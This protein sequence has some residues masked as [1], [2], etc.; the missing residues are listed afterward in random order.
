MK[1]WILYLLAG[2]ILLVC[3]RQGLAAN[4]QKRTAGCL[5]VSRLC[6]FILL[7]AKIVTFL[8]GF[9][10]LALLQTCLLIVD[11]VLIEMAFRKKRLTFG[12][13]HLNNL[14]LALSF[15]IV[16]INIF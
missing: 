5:I 9:N 1:N 13:P 10:W 14:T 7:I 11:F 16:I 3:I 8:T 4:M 15:L 6:L 2:L 12:D